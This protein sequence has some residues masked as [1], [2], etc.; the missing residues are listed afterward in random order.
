M[1]RHSL[2]PE[3]HSLCEEARRIVLWAGS[4]TEPGEE[5]GGKGEQLR[6]AARLLQLHEG[7]VWRAYQRRSGPEIFPTIWEARNQL[8]E[9]LA[10]QHARQSSPWQLDGR[11]ICS[12]PQRATD[13]AGS[14]LPRRVTTPKKRRA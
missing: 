8:I 12:V 11:S 10:N 1:G 14:L 3:K 4:L 13:P 9:R 2:C 5:I 7:V 6:R